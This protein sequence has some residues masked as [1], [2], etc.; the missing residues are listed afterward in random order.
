MQHLLLSLCIDIYLCSSRYTWDFHRLFSESQHNTEKYREILRYPA[1]HG[2]GEGREDLGKP[3]EARRLKPALLA[4]SHSASSSY[5]LP[6]RLHNV[7]QGMR[8]QKN[9]IGP[10][11]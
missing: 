8:I 2:K 9:K 3:V 7:V 10:S 1:F 11:G 5:V 6:V 4:N